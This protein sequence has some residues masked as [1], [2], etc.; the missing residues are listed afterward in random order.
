[1]DYLRCAFPTHPGALHEARRVFGERRGWR[2]GQGGRF[3]YG[4]HSRRGN[5]LLLHSEAGDRVCAELT[6]EGCREW[7]RE[8]DAE[9]GAG[10]GTR[11]WQELF[12]ELADAGCSFSRADF[13]LDDGGGVLDLERIVACVEAGACVTRFRR[14][15][16]QRNR[17]P[18]HPEQVTLGVTWGSRT[19]DTYLRIYDRGFRPGGLRT[20]PA[21]S[22]TVRVEVEAKKRRADALVRAFTADGAAAIVRDVYAHLDFKDGEA[23]LGGRDTNRSR[24]K[25]CDWWARFL[26]DADKARVVAVARPK[27]L[28]DVAARIEVQDAAWLALLVDAPGFGPAWLKRVLSEGRAR[29]EQRHLYLLD[30]HRRNQDASPPHFSEPKSAVLT[31]ETLQGEFDERQ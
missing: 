18:A 20:D 25:T 22:G 3:G 29:W 9:P 23:L 26:G 19:S 17:H 28:A 11:G 24:W 13:A 10:P 2:T 7:E 6:G 12:R 30:L 1:V 8:Q 14:V 16:V 15:T 21:A 5:I 27:S 4:R 31:G